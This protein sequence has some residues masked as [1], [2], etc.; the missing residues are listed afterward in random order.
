MERKDYLSG[1]KRIVVKAGTASLT[2]DRLVDAKKVM[3]LVRELSALHR[4]GYEILLVTS[5]AIA[6][7]IG[8]LGLKK[9]PSGIPE[10]QASASV[11]QIAL[12]THYHNYFKKYGITAGQVLLTESDL[13]DRVKY[14]NA[15][16]ALLT[17]LGPYRVVPV[18]NEND[19]VGI[20]EIIFGDND[21]LSA[22]MANLVS[23][24]LLIL[25]TDTEGFYQ[26]EEGKRTLLCDVSGG[27]DSLMKDAGGCGHELG[28]GGMKSKLQAVKIVTHAGIPAVIAK[29]SEKD[30]LGRVIRG[31]RIGTFFFPQEKGLSHRKR[32]IAFSSVP[33][34]R[35]FVDDGAREAI[36]VKSK[37]LLAR[38][39]TKVEGGFSQGDTVDICDSSGKVI[40]RG[41]TNYAV[42]V[43]ESIRGKKSPEIRKML[44]DEF[45][46][47]AVHR[48]NLAVF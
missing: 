6:S 36:V 26:M 42:S 40:A 41:I 37:S 9:R 20:E 10:K 28:T 8:E 38:G 45:Y 17:L 14:L 19:V 34:G 47:E 1:L 35:I 30:I 29:S 22:L 21:V 33:Q 25:L 12:M 7:G 15:R 24:D 46:E 3:K 11:G 48:D 2:T 18:V 27:V 16:N 5:G 23:A 43:L 32:W 4:K 39:I 31:E 44:E 13:K